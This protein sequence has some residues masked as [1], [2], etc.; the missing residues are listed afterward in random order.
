MRYLLDTNVLSNV[1]KGDT[2]TTER[3]FR[4]PRSQLGLPAPVLGEVIHGLTRMPVSRRRAA[5]EAH[6]TSFL[7]LV[8]V[9]PWSEDA[10]RVFGELKTTLE[11]SGGR[12]DDFDLAIASSALAL[13]ATL[14]TADD[15]FRRIP[16]LS[17]E[18]WSP[19]RSH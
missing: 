16:G 2:R 15:H 7:G 19:Q 6:L 14:L 4:I 18:D 1:L 3:L 11:R 17:L 13:D 10:A 9:L 12:L 5:L 8:K